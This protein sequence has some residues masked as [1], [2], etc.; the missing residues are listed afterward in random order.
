MFLESLLP[1]GGD[2]LDLLRG[3]GVSGVLP[4]AAHTFR[5]ETRPSISPPPPDSAK[6]EPCWW[7]GL[8]SRLSKQDHSEGVTG[9]GQGGGQATP[10]YSS[11]PTQDRRGPG[12]AND[13][14]GFARAREHSCA[15]PLKRTILHH[16]PGASLSSLG[17]TVQNPGAAWSLLRLA[18]GSP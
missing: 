2:P 10:R 14:P 13:I 1:L 5:D 15:H 16:H 18:Q 7:G 3:S 9:R 12:G 11:C 17:E 6:Q 8:L 4:G